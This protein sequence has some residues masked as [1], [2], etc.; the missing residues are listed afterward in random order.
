MKTLNLLSPGDQ[1]AQTVNT[2]PSLVSVEEGADLSS[3][4][5]VF[6][7]PTLEKILRSPLY[8]SQVGRIHKWYH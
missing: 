4:C 7:T 3:T 8:L 2:W 5:V 6:P 1:V